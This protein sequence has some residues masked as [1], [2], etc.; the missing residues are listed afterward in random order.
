[1]DID[2]TMP[3]TA[4]AVHTPAAEASSPPKKRRIALGVTALVVAA[5]AAYWYRG[6]F[7]EET[8]NAQVD[9]YISNVAS[10]V[11]GT[12]VAVH[13]D[14]NQ[15]VTAGQALV[16]LD[17]K[18][19]RVAVAQA[20]AS[21]AQAE[22]QLRAEEPS[23]AITETTNATLVAT[24][25]SDVASGRAGVAEA[26]RSVAQA[27]A[28]LKQG[29]ANYKLAQLDL[30]RAERLYQTGAVAKAEYDSKKAAAD[31]QTANVQAL[32]ETVDVTRRRVED[33]TARAR[34]AG[35]RARE[36]TVNASP[37]LEAKRATV[38]LRQ[39]NVEANKA[40]LEQA[41]LNL[42]YAKIPAPAGGV[43][44]KRSVNVG[45]R[46]NIGQQLLALA[47]TDKVWVTANFR[48]TQV[49]R[50]H[51]GQH[52]KVYVDAL[53]QHFEGEVESLAAATGSRYS[54]LPPENATGNYVKVVQR[55]PVRIRLLPGQQ[56]LERLRPGMSVEPEVR[57]K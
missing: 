20:K 57:V 23:V 51:P 3:A 48:E 53:D 17:P 43:I 1:M 42:S 55:L 5:S 46:V 27:E 7:Y 22:A 24:T 40:A 38:A 14:D 26:L 2:S 52:V 11:A 15:A 6:T 44:G 31:A 28:Q 19:L 10:R 25:T 21:L 56:G 41:E 47:Q 9:G 37:Q 49:T 18:D 54:I 30:E 12:V 13:V 29:E 50:M 4:P 45:D 33:Q 34:A 8:D 39:A 16:E 32:R 36:A 35:S